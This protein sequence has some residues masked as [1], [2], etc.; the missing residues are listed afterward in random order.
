MSVSD[1]E[2]HADHCAVDTTINGTNKA[3]IDSQYRSL[4][5]HSKPYSDTHSAHVAAQCGAHC[6]QHRTFRGANNQPV[7]RT[8]K[9]SESVSQCGPVRRAD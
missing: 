8:N 1:S 6:A 9:A 7:V 4:G 3:H 2:R 5:P